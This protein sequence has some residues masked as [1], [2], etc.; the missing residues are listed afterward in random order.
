MICDII[1]KINEEE[2]TNGFHIEMEMWEEIFIYI[3]SL[4]IKL[5]K[6]KQK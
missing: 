4:C 2:R 3:S 6:S 1:N 5:E